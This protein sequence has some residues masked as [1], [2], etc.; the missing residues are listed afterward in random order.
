VATTGYGKRKEE[1]QKRAYALLGKSVGDVYVVA[2]PGERR[3]LDTRIWL[4]IDV[5]GFHSG[6]N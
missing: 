4:L 6:T 3:R 2:L 5:S 1:G